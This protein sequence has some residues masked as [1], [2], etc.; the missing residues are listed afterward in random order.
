MTPFVIN[1]VFFLV[2]GPL[3][4]RLS[5]LLDLVTLCHLMNYDYKVLWGPPEEGCQ[6]QLND[7]LIN[8]EILSRV[9]KDVSILHE[10][11]SYYYNPKIPSH[12]ILQQSQVT[13]KHHSGLHENVD[14]HE[15]LV[16]ASE[17]EANLVPPTMNYISY[18]LER[19][20]QYQL[21]EFDFTITGYLNAMK[22]EYGDNVIG[23]YVKNREDFVD[24]YYL[25]FIRC[26]NPSAKVFVGFSGEVSVKDRKE[27]I[28]ILKDH[29]PPSRMFQLSIQEED[30]TTT[31]TS[32]VDNR[33]LDDLLT[34]ACFVDGCK[35][36]ITEEGSM[37]EYIKIVVATNLTRL[38][39]VDR[40]SRSSRVENCSY[41]QLFLM[42]AN[43]DGNSINHISS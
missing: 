7:I 21:W 22:N 41:E 33:S 2:S 20:K 10:S 14:F 32:G 31:S 26:L 18:N 37:D 12:L 25:D 16:I 38:C 17:A 34:F 11:S 43:H 5:S 24:T 1:K 6:L 40:K 9:V 4:K 8:K 15:W 13:R 27:V 3:H 29:N 35:V 36:L 28:K 42:S 39:V 19:Q 23:L 30:S